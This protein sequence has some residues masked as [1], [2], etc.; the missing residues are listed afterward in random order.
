MH[1]NVNLDELYQ[2]III[3]HYKHPRHACAVTEEDAQVDEE[4]PT[5][6][7]QIRLIAE[8]DSGTVTDIKYEAHGC[9]ISVASASMMAETLVGKPIEEARAFIKRFVAMMKGK[10]EI[11]EDE[12][13]DLVALEG[14]KHFPLRIK[15]AT[16]SW[17]AAEKALS[18][19]ANPE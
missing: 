18:L 15:C 19:S 14:V 6:G 16:M 1:D 17:H 5:C 2:E 3:D 9:A 10:A 12:L 11:D 8:V 13:E 4:N 7:D